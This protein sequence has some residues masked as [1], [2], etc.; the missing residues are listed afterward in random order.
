M[1]TSVVLDTAGVVAVGE[2]K[3]SPAP[4]YMYRAKTLEGQSLRAGA[5][6]A[7]TAGGRGIS[8]RA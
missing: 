3:S 1:N 8:S 4:M 6:P 2:L 5:M 7:E